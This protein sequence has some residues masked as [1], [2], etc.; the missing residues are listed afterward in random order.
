MRLFSIRNRLRQ[1]PFPHI[2]PYIYFSCDAAQHSTGPIS[3]SDQGLFNTALPSMHAR[4]YSIRSRSQNVRFFTGPTKYHRKLIPSSCFLNFI[5]EISKESYGCTKS[6]V[7][8]GKYRNSVLIARCK[9][10]TSIIIKPK[11]RLLAA[12]R[13]ARF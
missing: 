12:F 8:F 5:F 11:M 4:Y 13:V 7:L 1:S 2:E 9:N 6:V 3:N 10:V